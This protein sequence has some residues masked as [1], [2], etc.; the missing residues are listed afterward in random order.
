MRKYS[1]SR[2]FPSKGF[3]LV[4]LLV[5]SAVFA[6]I[7]I[8]VYQ[9]YASLTTLVSASRVKILATDLLN[10]QF[11]L[12]RNLPYGE[13]GLSGGIPS[14]VLS[15]T[16][17]FIRGAHTFVVTRTI[18]N[19]DD[20]FDGT[21]GGSPN[22]LSPADS[23][24]VEVVVSCD[25]CQAFSPLSL[26]GRVAPKNLE[27]ASQN[28][29][30]FIRVFD[31]NGVEI[32]G[33]QVHV[34]NNTL[35]P[36]IVIDD[37]T[38]AQG[39][40]Q[41]VDAP[42][43]GNAYEIVVTKSGYTTERTY[44]SST[45]GA[46]PVKPHATVAVQQVTQI[47]FVIDK[48]STARVETLTPS[49]ASVPSVP[50]TIKGSKLLGTSP[51]VF[52][53]NSNLSTD[54]SGINT[55]TDLEWDTYGITLGSVSHVLAG[56]NPLLPIAILPDAFYNIQFILSADSPSHV[57]VSV[58]DN[59][60]QLPLSGAKVTLSD[61]AFSEILYTGRGFM[62]QTDWSGGSGQVN[63][64]N[65]TQY[66]SSDGNVE[67]T[68]TPGIVKL[69]S[70]FGNFASS[71]ELVSSI[72]DTGTTTNFHQISWTPTAQPPE[73]GVP[74]VRFQVATSLDNTSTTTWA[75]RGPDGTGGT[76][77]DLSNTNIH[78]SH[79]GDRYFRYKMY[80]GTASTTYTPTIANVAL[81]FTTACVPPGQVLF[82]SLGSSTYT[83]SVELT[84][85]ATQQVQ[86]P[87]SSNS[88]QRQDII[89][90]PE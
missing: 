17:T 61:G 63:F 26:S 49:C 31:A 62:E 57:L 46:T 68:Q 35:S 36:A 89:L 56:V 69:S 42:P 15:P 30:L 50:F 13:V 87:V 8:S 48:V 28:G 9:G 4:E 37:V 18:R 80:L 78:D 25:T 54:S 5:G 75:Y 74:N 51:D 60:T 70:A 19:I 20:P 11:E 52:K 84:G 65:S 6:L 58:R 59:T 41:I 76:F 32:Q 82:S 45:I 38:D 71:G 2:S 79:D 7:A 53:V 22:D 34:E 16:Q 85:Y 3:S 27:T 43:G 73:T 64:S 40:L 55:I 1:S 23:K 39:M 83:L 14:G 81:T 10:E 44:A 67:T 33:A 21:I 12:V 47:S 24:L 29:A 88:W 66:F 77:Y 86:V 90:I 72:F